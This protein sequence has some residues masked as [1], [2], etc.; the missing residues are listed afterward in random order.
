VKNLRLIFV[1]AL[2]AV[3]AGSTMLAKKVTAS[4][5]GDTCIRLTKICTTSCT[6]RGGTYCRPAND[7]TDP[8]TY[9]CACENIKF[10]GPC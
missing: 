10:G 6:G 3:S 4:T 7:C 1:V 5:C 8:C 9:V 2:L